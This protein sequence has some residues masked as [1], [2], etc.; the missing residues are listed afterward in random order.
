MTEGTF[1]NSV[2]ASVLLGAFK[3]ASCILGSVLR[4]CSDA[5]DAFCLFGIPDPTRESVGQKPVF[6]IEQ[7]RLLG[8]SISHR[9]L[10]VS[11]TILIIE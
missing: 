2:L 3:S 4:P 10:N 8:L 11:S 6:I 1:L 9:L 7:Q 5:D